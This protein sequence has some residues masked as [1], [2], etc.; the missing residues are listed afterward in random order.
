LDLQELE[1]AKNDHEQVFVKLE[2]VQQVSLVLQ[3]AQVLQL[4]Q[5]LLVVQLVQVFAR[6]VLPQLLVLAVFH[7]VALL[8]LVHLMKKSKKKMNQNYLG[9]RF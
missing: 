1:I 7:R 2:F 3:R 5:V 6:Q 9:Y 8:Q 4:V